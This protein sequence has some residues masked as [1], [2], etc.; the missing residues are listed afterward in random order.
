MSKRKR[1]TI[2]KNARKGRAKGQGFDDLQEGEFEELSTIVEAIIRFPELRTEL[3]CVESS[4]VYRS[5]T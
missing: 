5:S 3:V 1:V 4:A 2:S